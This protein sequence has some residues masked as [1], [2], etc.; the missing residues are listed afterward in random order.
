M[1]APAYAKDGAAPPA[2]KCGS[3]VQFV[4]A[5]PNADTLIVGPSYKRRGLIL[6]VDQNTAVYL[7]NHKMT[8]TAQGWPIRVESGALY[9][10]LYIHGDVVQKEWHIWSGNF[11]TT[12]GVI[13]VMQ[14]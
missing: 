10:C 3:V 14:L 7:A 6:T 8:A 4:A 11:T 13:E 2:D 1:S 5:A 9:L 12:V